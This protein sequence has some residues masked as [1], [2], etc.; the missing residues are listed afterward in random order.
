MKKII[1][2]MLVF[3]S[4]LLTGCSGIPSNKDLYEITDEFLEDYFAGKSF[5]SDF[6]EIT[7]ENIGEYFETVDIYI[8]SLDGYF[9]E[10]FQ[11]TFED[12]FG[13]KFFDRAM[14][15]MHCY[16]IESEISETDYSIE[17]EITEESGKV[18][19]S[20][21]FLA[22]ENEDGST[23]EIIFEGWV[24]FDF[25]EGKTLISDLGTVKL[26]GYPDQ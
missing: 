1:I 10:E 23:F 9:T 17:N 3:V 11:V 4:V 25:T 13:I 12:N 18:N 21:T 5:G 26:T 20:I 7:P 15:N 24:L 19:F 2:V 8:E 16:D 14:M 22:T 6:C